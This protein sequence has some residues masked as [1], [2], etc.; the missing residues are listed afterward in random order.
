MHRGGPALTITVEDLEAAGLGEQ[1]TAV[2]EAVERYLEGEV[3]NVAVVTEPFAGREVFLD[4]AEEVFGAATGR[5]T[6]EEVVTG[7][8]PEFPV[9]EIV[10]VDNCHYLYTREIGGFDVLER[11]LDRVARRDA[12]Y[13][14]SWNR[15]AWAYLSAVSNVDDAF[16]E[17]INI[18][19]LDADQIADLIAS[20]H[21][22]PLPMFVD[23]GD[24]GRVKTVDV[25]W[26]SLSLV[27]DRTVPV[28]R[29]QLHTEYA[30]SRM[31]SETDIG[32][33]AAVYR[34]IARL[35]EGDPGVAVAIWDRSVRD[36]KIAPSYVQEVDRPLDIDHDDAF[37]LEVILTNERIE[38]EQIARVCDD[39]PVEQSLQTLSAHGVISIDDEDRVGI[40]PLR[41][42]STVEHLAG[43][44]LVW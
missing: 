34:R 28:P 37:V 24:T 32:I 7:E 12:L 29:P 36:G 13:V 31:R 26:R 10:L 27:G 15:Y 3:S 22:T 4:Y 6:F 39:I 44:Q 35:S 11:F 19:P 38:R 20:Y 18:P 16:P 25:E 1:F 43:R 17:T 33:E 41:L 23:D 9:A 30:F 8:L 21:G 42:H 5:V 14:T 40:D 2:E